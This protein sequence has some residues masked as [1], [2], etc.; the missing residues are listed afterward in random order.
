MR[1]RSVLASLSAC[2]GLAGCRSVGTPDPTDN[3]TETPPTCESPSTRRVELAGT[4]ALPAAAGVSATVTTERTRSTA[5]APARFTVAL[6]N[7]GSDCAVDAT[8][9]GRCHLL[10]RGA[11]RSEPRGL[12]LYRAGDAPTDRAGEC[13]TRD[14]PPRDSVGF[15]GYG[16][17][18][19]P[20]DSGETVGTTYE[21]WDDYTADGYLRP[22]TYRFDVSIA[23]WAETPDEEDGT[24]P[25]PAVVD[26]WFELS[27][28]A[29]G[30]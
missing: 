18:R 5:E 24:D 16:C 20:F 21:V 27:V 19:Y 8:D 10:N 3:S 1:R 2:A 29:D 6:T 17:G 22:G 23:L 14:L 12:W 25:D 15:D 28:S 30:G 7:D 26:W 11:G 4:G 13:W 9:D